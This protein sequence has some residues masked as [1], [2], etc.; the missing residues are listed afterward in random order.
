MSLV[1]YITYLKL[2]IQELRYQLSCALAREK[3]YE[4][5]LKKTPPEDCPPP[6]PPELPQQTKSYW[7]WFKSS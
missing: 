5:L 1:E 4:P 3:L 6:P 7:D 2:E